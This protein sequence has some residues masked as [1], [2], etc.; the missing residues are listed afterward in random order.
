MKE[1]YHEPIKIINEPDYNYHTLD[2]PTITDQEY[3]KYLRE[4]FELLGANVKFSMENNFSTVSLNQ[5]T[6]KITVLSLR[7]KIQVL[8]LTIQTVYGKVIFPC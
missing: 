7:N 1:R 8:N 2:N 6:V 4:L 5:K 3:D